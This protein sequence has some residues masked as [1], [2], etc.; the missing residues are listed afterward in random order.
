MMGASA[1]D[2]WNEYSEKDEET[3][4]LFYLKISSC[5]WDH[6]KHDN[7]S[8]DHWKAGERS[9]INEDELPEKMSFENIVI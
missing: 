2:Y 4:K 6:L 5:R 3:S 8:C 9:L 7:I 1:T